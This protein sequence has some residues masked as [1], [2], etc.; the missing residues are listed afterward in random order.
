M[1][2][3]WTNGRIP[4]RRWRYTLALLTAAAIPLAGCSD[5]PVGVEDDPG[6]VEM[7]VRDGNGASASL[8]GPSLDS[9]DGASGEFRA[10][11]RVQVQ[12][13]GDWQDVVDLAGVQAQ[14]ELRGG[15][16]TVGMA[17][18]E[19]RTYDRVRVVVNN[20]R[21]DL[22]AG[23][24]IGAGPIDASVSLEIAGGGEAAIEYGAPVTVQANSTTRIML[25]L[26]SDLWLTGQTIEAGAV[27]RA[28][29]ESAAVVVVQ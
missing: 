22:D 12:V 23:V 25:N 28:A 3:K 7:V 29:F 16:S 8:G 20:A 2:Q 27:T 10:D 4:G 13:D 11:V 6:S 14:V 5:D 17:T 21:A 18:V 1:D 24:D 26:N 19:A 9:H 15:E